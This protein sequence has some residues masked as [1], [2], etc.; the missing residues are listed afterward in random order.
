M[1]MAGLK[2]VTWRAAGSDMRDVYRH[3]RIVLAPSRWSEAWCRVVTEAH[4]SGIPVIATGIGGLPES[5][6]DGG[7]LRPADAGIDRWANAVESLLT[8]PAVYERYVAA[9]RTASQRPEIDENYL[10]ERLLATFS[11]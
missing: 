11:N 1:T 5:V 4:I 3:A 6:G 7:I 8:D 10:V 2:N 9:A